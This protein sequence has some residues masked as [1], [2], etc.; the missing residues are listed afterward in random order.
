[1]LY[2]IQIYFFTCL[3]S[4]YRYISGLELYTLVK[5]HHMITQLMDVSKTASHPLLDLH[6]LTQTLC[7]YRRMLLLYHCK[8]TV[9]NIKTM[10][11]KKKYLRFYNFLKG[12]HASETKKIY[13]HSNLDITNL[14]IVNKTQLPF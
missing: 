2:L 4:W 9:H 14:D 3:I 12:V 13:I 11:R 7:R 5:L 6:L 8:T 10:P 1:M